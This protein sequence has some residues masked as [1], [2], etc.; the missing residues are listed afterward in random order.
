M[1]TWA[2]HA[3]ALPVLREI[4]DAPPS[5]ELRPIAD[6]ET[7]DYTQTDE[8]DMGMSYAELGVFGTLRK[9]QRC[10]PVTMFVQLLRGAWK[11]LQ[12]ADIAAKVRNA[13]GFPPPHYTVCLARGYGY[14]CGHGRPC[15]AIALVEASRCDPARHFLP[16]HTPPY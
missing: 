7:A 13:A 14:G 11:H 15:W 8:E 3:H 4:A 2:A 5:A 16:A 9:V 12:A 6:G 10:G 1:M